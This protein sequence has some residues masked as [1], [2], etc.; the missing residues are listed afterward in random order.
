LRFESGAPRILS[1]VAGELEEADG[2]VLSYGDNA[3]LPAKH[4]FEYTAKA[5][6]EVLV[7]SQF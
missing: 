7:T 4:A 6:S 1:I 2:S 5:A 3:L